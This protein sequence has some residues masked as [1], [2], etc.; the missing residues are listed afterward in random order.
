MRVSFSKRYAKK[1][2]KNKKA[3]SSEKKQAYRLTF[4]PS[5]AEKNHFFPWRSIMLSVLF[6]IIV[7][8][9]AVVVHYRDQMLFPIK[10]IDVQGQF[11]TV[12]TENLQSVFAKY[13]SGSMLFLSEHQLAQ[14]LQSIPVIDQVLVKRIWPS[15]V[16]IVLQQKYPIARF[17][18]TQ[19]L[20]NRG[21]LF[22]PSDMH[23]AEGLPY[24][25]G[26]E[27]RANQLWQVYITLNKILLPV[28]LKILRLEVSPRLSYSLVLNNGLTLYLG[29]TDIAERVSL[30]VRVYA[31]SLHARIAQMDYVDMRYNSGMAVGWKVLPSQNASLKQKEKV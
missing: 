12:K 31:K 11:D 5:P 2:L 21:I 30:F 14:A 3:K 4:T 20:S 26:P 22:L 1:E 13:A 7:A 16:Q 28:D 29:S 8:L 10:H 27:S 6:M 24:I 23:Q 18:E 25:N 19:L 15:T 9:C 17:G